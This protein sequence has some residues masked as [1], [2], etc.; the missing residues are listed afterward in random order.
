ITPTPTATPGG[1]PPRI[2][3]SEFMANP[4]AVADDAG[5]WIEL[6]NADANA[7]NLRDWVLRDGGNDRHRIAADLHLQPG[8]YAVLGVDADPAVN[9][10]VFMRY[11]Y[12]SV[13][14]ANRGDT[15]VLELPDGRVADS[16]RW[17]E[18][19]G[20]VTTAGASLERMA[21]DPGAAWTTAQQP[22]PGSAGDFGSP[23]QG[24][25]AQP[26]P[27]PVATM[28][29]AWMSVSAPTALQ[30][31]EF[32]YQGSGEEFVALLNN[33]DSAVNLAGWGIGDAQQ[34]EG[35]EGIYRLP[36][37]L[38]LAP[39][40]LY[41]VARDAATFHTRFGRQPMAEFE[42][43]DPNVPTL[44]RRTDLGTGRLALDDGGDEIVLIN[45]ALE[46][47]DAVAYGDGD[48][49]ALGLTGVLRAPSGLSAQRVPQTGF[50][51][52]ADVRHR[53]LLALPDPFAARTLP[54]A[55]TTDAPQL[56]DNFIAVWGALGMESIFTPGFT[57]PPHYLLA[58]ARSQGL[59]FAAIADTAVWEPAVSQPPDL[60]TFPAWRW[61]GDDGAA[62][63]L[64][65]NHAAPITGLDGLATYLAETGADVQ[66]LGDNNPNLPGLFG[67][68]PPSAAPP[69]NLATWFSVWSDLSAPLLPVGNG[70]PDLPGALAIRPRYTG[71]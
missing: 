29:A 36:D 19:A 55:G 45:P 3:I 63:I 14:L 42:D 18:E 1:P 28:P 43:G 31:E 56:S 59:D 23:G 62:A 35:S 58:A 21:T 6:V 57:A 70:S 5:E 33:S 26:T 61:Q 68:T 13:G 51:F 46:L 10:G 67:H 64:Y 2:L 12:R 53:F 11:T 69:D 22:W 20:L 16:I 7:V 27:T 48:F 34:P 44:M 32:A 24:Y 49:G 37:T 60:I 39:G 40:E 41:V 50:P 17:G 15:L 47:A 25:I 71:L 8:E 30:I 52:V 9:G 38:V 66:W 4:Q 54:Q 65:H